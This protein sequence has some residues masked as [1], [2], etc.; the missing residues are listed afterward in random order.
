M[1]NWLQ[2]LGYTLGQHHTTFFILLMI[3]N[4]WDA[5]ITAIMIEAGAA[6]EANPVMAML[7]EYFGIGGFVFFK[8][9]IVNPFIVVVARLVNNLP[10]DSKTR[11]VSGWLL[12]V[13]TVMYALLGIYHIFGILW[14][15]ELL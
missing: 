9:L 8:L 13:D 2:K 15:F 10:A 11:I 14:V 6:E 7:M 5:V 4:A 1:K 12:L 3:L